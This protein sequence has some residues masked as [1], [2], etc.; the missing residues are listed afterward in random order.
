MSGTFSHW[1]KKY[2]IWW[3]PS[4]AKGDIIFFSLKAAKAL[5]PSISGE[6]KTSEYFSVRWRWRSIWWRVS[7]TTIQYT[8]S[9]PK[10]N[11]V[12]NKRMLEWQKFHGRKTAFGQLHASRI[13]LQRI[14]RQSLTPRDM[15]H[16]RPKKIHR[17]SPSSIVWCP[18]GK[19]MFR[20]SP[21]ENLESYVCSD[22]GI[23][24]E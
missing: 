9:V 22:R 1:K 13:Y 4:I 17:L 20:S 18:H 5:V 12:Y 15:E 24:W 3:K 8:Q 21:V 14:L 11:T 19:G 23:I 7:A 6:Q 10:T 2:L 16:M